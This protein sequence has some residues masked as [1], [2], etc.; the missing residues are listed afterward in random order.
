[1]KDDE[2]TKVGQIVD[3]ISRR[4]YEH[5]RDFGPGENTN[6][7]Q[8]S[9]LEFMALEHWMLTTCTFLDEEATYLDS[10]RVMFKG[11]RI[12]PERN[13]IR[14]TRWEFSHLASLE[15]AHL[16]AAV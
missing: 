6:V 5:R 13:G 8:I 4:I 11:W 15:R 2:R 7:M 10:E 14:L 3:S 9:V 16:K 1:M 12:F